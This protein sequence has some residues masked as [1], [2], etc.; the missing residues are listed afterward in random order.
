MGLFNSGDCEQA[1][2]LRGHHLISSKQGAGSWYAHAIVMVEL[3]LPDRNS[4]NYQHN[5]Q[6]TEAEALNEE[7][8]RRTGRQKTS[9]IPVPLRVL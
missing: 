5:A 4:G 3:N 1:F 6:C 8:W 7:Y 9:I 2:Q